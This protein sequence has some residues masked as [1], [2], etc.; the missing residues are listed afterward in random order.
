MNL[1]FL[2]NKRNAYVFRIN[3]IRGNSIGYTNSMYSEYGI[4]TNPH[5]P[6]SMYLIDV[7]KVIFKNNL[8]NISINSVNK[9]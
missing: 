6:S 3:T 8:Y 5:L 9:I 1:K 2:K 7:F 4:I